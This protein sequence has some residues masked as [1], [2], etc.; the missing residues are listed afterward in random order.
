MAA[1][2]PGS[3][4]GAAFDASF[5]LAKVEDVSSEYAA[6]ED[7]FVAGLEF[8]EANG[9]D[10]ATSSVVIFNHYTPE[11][12]DGQTTVMTVGLNVAAENGLHCFQGAGNDGHDD[13]PSTFSL[14]PPAD[15]LK[16][17]TVGAVTG[18]GTIASFSSDGP[19]AD[20]RL[21]PEVLAR[22]V[23]TWTVHPND[24]DAYLAVNG[25]S[26]STPL[27]AAA[28][29]CLVGLH[30]EWTVDQLR[31]AMFQTADQYTANGE[32]DPLFV[33]GFGILDV[34]AAANTMPSIADL[35]GDF[36]VDVNDLVQLLLAWGPCTCPEDLDGDGV[37]GVTDLITLIS[38]WG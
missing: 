27:T 24:A 22:G 3:L 37:V 19:T 9:G 35:N 28:A 36:A 16:V 31:S 29:A 4:V 11:E 21:K 7:F 2:F 15:A 18:A 20:G 17:V 1:Y 33:H 32:P 13:D 12:L 30:P 23:S 10:V 14:V 38:E 34:L 8:I 25:T 6:E 26:L 5:I